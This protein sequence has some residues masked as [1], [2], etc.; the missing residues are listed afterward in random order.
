METHKF[1]S[2][3]KFRERLPTPARE[4]WLSSSLCEPSLHANS[5]LVYSCSRPSHAAEHDAPREARRLF[6]CVMMA[7]RGAAGH[8]ISEVSRQA[9][10]DLVPAQ[11][12]VGVSAEPPIHPSDLVHGGRGL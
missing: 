7:R 5:Y 12:Q 6:P 4:R 10:R 3:N 1:S 2:Q 11:G 8:T 9:T